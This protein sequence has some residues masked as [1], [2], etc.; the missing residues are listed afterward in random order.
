MHYS[1]TARFHTSCCLICICFTHVEP[2]RTPV[3]RDE[4]YSPSCLTGWALEH[5]IDLDA[6]HP[7]VLRF[8]SERA[9][10]A[11]EASFLRWRICGQDQLPTSQPASARASPRSIGNSPRGRADQANDR[12]DENLIPKLRICETLNH[13]RF[14]RSTD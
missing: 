6:A 3:P 10:V 9:H 11:A 8:T 14:S 1:K 4:D 7:G 12:K 13:P 2:R 5:L